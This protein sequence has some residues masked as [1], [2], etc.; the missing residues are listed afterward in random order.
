MLS[1]SVHEKAARRTLMKLTPG[2]ENS[3]ITNYVF[4]HVTKSVTDLD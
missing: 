4:Y 2:I 3:L 1:G